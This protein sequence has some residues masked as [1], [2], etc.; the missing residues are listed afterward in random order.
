LDE[1]LGVECAARA[2]DG[3]DDVHAGVI[4][5]GV[6]AGVGAGAKN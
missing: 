1:A 6:R 4:V 3:G 2:G 5:A